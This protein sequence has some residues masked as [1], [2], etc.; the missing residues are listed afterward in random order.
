MSKFDD[1]PMDM[2]ASH[3][4]NAPQQQAQ[5]PAQQ[6]TVQQQPSTF[7]Q[8]PIQQQYQSLFA[9]T[10]YGASWTAANTQIPLSSTPVLQPTQQSST[11]AQASSSANQQGKMPMMDDP[12][13]QAM[14]EFF[15][16][17]STAIARQTDV[18]ERILRHQGG[19]GLHMNLPHF[20]G[21]AGE[22]VS[23]W[24]FQC[25]EVFVAKGMNDNRQ[26]MHHLAGCL[27]DAALHW[28]QQACLQ[29]TDGYL[30][31]EDWEEFVLEIKKAFQPPN[32][33]QV[34]RRQ[35]R[36]LRQ[37]GDIRDY[38]YR[39]RNLVGQI[40]GMGQLD[41][42]MHFVDGLKP[43]TQTEV[44]YRAPDTLAEAME[45]AI[46]YDT[47]RF[48][49]GRAPGNTNS[50]QPRYIPHQR[51]DNGGPRPMELDN[52]NRRNHG[53]QNRL[54][55]AE[56]A[57]LRREN[58]CF[59]CQE[60]GHMARDCN[61]RPNQPRQQQGNRQAPR[62]AVAEPQQ[63]IHQGP[64]AINH[65]HTPSEDYT[66][67]Q[68]IKIQGRVNGQEAIVLIDSGASKNYLNSKF[69]KKHQI[70]VN[71]QAATHPII[72]LADSTTSLYEE[73]VQDFMIE[74]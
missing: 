38:I 24:L 5:Q 29:G 14:M 41:Q 4:Q 32:N 21:K 17:L 53:Q 50:H 3:Q 16:N 73:Q 37:T 63:P 62:A 43:A 72:E 26:R 48:G 6:P 42:V 69:A 22:N 54:T 67:E 33:Q 65:V 9:Q 49:P 52:I 19:S 28:Y 68:L 30:P 46:T 44:N 61:R 57:R 13:D 55:D 20:H 8:Q 35:V 36:G 7:Q 1:V 70:T 34:L 18:N 39:F 47:A 31:F 27:H 23:I 45:I 10:P 40:T 60:A 2:A 64:P 66:R 59:K 15:T 51:R 11:Q 56:K 58:K 12:K 74:L 25:D 71:P